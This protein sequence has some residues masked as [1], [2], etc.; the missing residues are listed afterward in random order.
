MRTRVVR[1]VHHNEG[2]PH[3][4][5][6]ADEEIPTMSSPHMKVPTPVIGGPDPHVLGTFYAKLLDW[7]VVELEP[8]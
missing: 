3:G 6:R 2:K 1:L 4:D 7:T 5:H 8:E